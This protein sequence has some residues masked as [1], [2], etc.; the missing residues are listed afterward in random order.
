MYVFENQTL[1]GLERYFLLCPCCFPKWRNTACS[2]H[3]TCKNHI[4]TWTLQHK[5]CHI[6]VHACFMQHTGNWDVFHA[7]YMHS[8]CRKINHVACMFPVLNCTYVACMSHAC[9]IIAACMLYSD[10]MHVAFKVHACHMH[11]Y[12]MY[13]N[14]TYNHMLRM[15]TT[16]IVVA[17]WIDK[18]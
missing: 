7:C 16:T 4:R 5:C 15:I 12:D 14:V 10:C 18:N 17:K 6:F 2:M 9:Y 3:A 1:S 11:A 13:N 8:A